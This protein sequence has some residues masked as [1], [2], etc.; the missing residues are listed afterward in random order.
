MTD[1]ARQAEERSRGPAS[2]SPERFDSATRTVREVA[3]ALE[4]GGDGPG[5]VYPRGA[6]IFL[7]AVGL[8]PEAAR[9]RAIEWGLARFLGRSSAQLRELDPATLTRWCISQYPSR[10][11]RAIVVGSPSGA[12]AHLAALLGAPFLTSSFLLSFRHRIA[13]DDIQSYREFGERV[14]ARLLERHEEF[15]AINHYDPLHDRALIKHADLLRL[16]LVRL[17]EAYCQFIRE[18]LARDGCLILI[19]CTYPWPQ[20]RLGER[21][22]LQ[23]GGLGGVSPE[24]FLRRWSLQQPLEERPESEWG[25]PP[26]LAQEVRRFARESRLELLELQLDHPQRYSLLAYRAYLAAGAREDEL[27]LDCFTYINPYTNLITAI[28]ALWLPYN[29]RESFGFARRFVAERGFARIYLA[30]ATSF[31]RCED[32]VA[33][34]EWARLLERKGQLELLGVDPRRYPADP[35]APFAY[36]GK[37]ARLREARAREERIHLEPRALQGLTEALELR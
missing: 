32:T 17:P 14:A 37:L 29:D 26:G 4:G 15:E 8:L 10:P 24:E 34:A 28:P 16:R 27:M 9:I 36:R 6:G 35:W 11:Y 31:A 3:L 5:E 19:S 2:L 20:Y 25:C 7:R 21:S 33:F 1:P 18:H 12:V 30:L 23:V 22:F 13:P